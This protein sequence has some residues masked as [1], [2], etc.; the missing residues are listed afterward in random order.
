MEAK[1]FFCKL[2]LSPTLYEAFQKQEDS[3]EVLNEFQKNIINEA[4]FAFSGHT[5]FFADCA[6]VSKTVMLF[7]GEKNLRV[8]L[9]TTHLPLANVPAAITPQLLSSIITLLRDG[10][11]RWFGLANPKILV[12]GL[13]PHAGESGQLGREEIEVIA[14]TLESLRM[15]GF[16]LTGPVSADTAFSTPGFDVVLAL[17]HDQALPVVKYASF[18]H[19]VNV[20]LGLP[21][22]RTSVDHGT[23][24]R[25]AGTGKAD[26]ASLVAALQ[27][28][29]QN[30]HR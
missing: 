4:G 16:D 2:V 18:G 20:T 23:A 26:A 15:Q 10:L 11:V 19:A 22:L 5:E 3:S 25:L 28:A 30:C 14:P 9:A 6:G 7:A 24:L 17:Y 27:L 8:A 29:L 21:F 1:Y 12:C 13:N